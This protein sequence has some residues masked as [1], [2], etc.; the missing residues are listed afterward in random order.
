MKKNTTTA[1]KTT[2]P[3]DLLE[4]QLWDNVA[5][6]V[7]QAG[8]GAELAGKEADKVIAARRASL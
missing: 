3:R 6:N 1:K 4:Q 5:L 2:K 8:K 7:I